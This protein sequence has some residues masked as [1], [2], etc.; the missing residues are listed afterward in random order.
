MYD[1]L[2]S[3]GPGCGAAYPESYWADTAGIPPQD[4]G[5]VTTDIDVE[6]AIIGGGY[7]GLSAAYHLASEHNFDAVVL[8]A[9]QTGWGC[10]GRNGGFALKAGGRLSY[11]KM[12]KRYGV[13]IGKRMFAEMF[14]GLERVRGLIK[15]NNID[16]EQQDDGHIWVAHRARMMNVISEEATFLKNQFDYDVDILSR[17]DLKKDFFDSDEAHGA[18]R[19]RHGFGIHPLKLAYGYHRLARLA[20]A[21][22]HPSSPVQQWTKEGGFHILVTPGGIVRAKKV[23]CA[24]NGYTAPSLH[25]KLKNRTLPVLSNVI[26]TRPLTNNELQTTNFITN[27]VITDTR[28]LRFYYRKLPD[29]R[30]LIGGRSAITGAEAENP[31]HNEN[32]LN[33]LKRKFSAL[34]DLSF[35]YQWGGWVSVSFDDIP[36]ICQQKDDSS[37]LYAMGY[38]GSGVSFAVQAGMRLAEKVAGISK[39]HDLPVL[40]TE[41]PKFPFAPF[42]RVGQRA[43]Y[44][45]YSAR[46]EKQ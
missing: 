23:I 26:V 46:D 32:L 21:R 36:H 45:Y 40:N 30:L 19:F 28:T 41:L 37:I 17:E 5:P 22:I 42:R 27:N 20:G 29:N 7:T 13:D 3:S 43:L 9:N 31:I 16:C 18:L 35:D 25:K 1:P 15:D 44:H 10:S 11:Q 38:G 6:V 14:E 8:E 4:D 12:I 34:D 39:N 2:V 24:T 33:G